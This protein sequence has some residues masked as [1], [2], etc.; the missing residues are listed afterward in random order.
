[1]VVDNKFTIII[2]SRNRCNDL[3]Q[4]LMS[5]EKLNFA[6]RI[7]IIICNDASTDD[8]KEMLRDEF[9]QIRVIHNKMHL[10][11][12]ESRNLLMNQVKTEYTVSLDD[13]A[14][15]LSEPDWSQI[16]S[17]FASNSRCA[18]LALRIF[19]G[20]NIPKSN[21]SN[22]QIEPVKSF[23]GCGH[24]WR[25]SAWNEVKFYP[26][27]FK[28]YGEEDF[29]SYKLFKSGYKI[30]YYPEILVHHRVDIKKRKE[31]KDYTNRTRM[32]LRSAWYLYFMFYPIAEIPKRFFYSIWMQ[33]KLK[34]FK[35][36]IKAFV[37]LILGFIDLIINSVRVVQNA[38]RLSKVE[39]KDF[40]KLVDTKIYWHQENGYN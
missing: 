25:M 21:L 19:W 39:F 6:S 27:W 2:T 24:I 29:M 11:L 30:Y 34:L 20:L 22:Q 3:R 13:D 12:I 1:M 37:G 40:Q 33:I 31:H 26:G 7:N 10:G 15:F 36:D 23:V 18:V 28:F 32:S 8:T 5:F 16:H 17:F 14:N 35:G 9:P 38:D 4:T